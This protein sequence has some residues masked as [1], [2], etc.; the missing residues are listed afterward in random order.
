MHDAIARAHVH[1]PGLIQARN[2][3]FLSYRIST[4]PITNV[5]RIAEVHHDPY[6]LVIQV[7]QARDRGQ[8]PI[9]VAGLA[10]R[11]ADGAGGVGVVDVSADSGLDLGGVEIVDVEVWWEGVWGELAEVILIAG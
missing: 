5:I 4:D 8:V 1:E 7:Q 9:V 10:E 6:A 11:S 3:S 2:S